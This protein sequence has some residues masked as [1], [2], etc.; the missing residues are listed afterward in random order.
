L[1]S[2]FKL[3]EESGVRY[4]ATK[5][6]LGYDLTDNA[7]V[8]YNTGII[9][10][11]AEFVKANS[12]YL[13]STTNVGA[14]A[15]G[16]PYSFNFWVKLTAEVTSGADFG[17]MGHTPGGTSGNRGWSGVYYSYNSGT[18]RLGFTRYDPTNND[19]NIYHNITLGTDDWHMITL[20]YNSSQLE[21]FVNGS[22]V[23]TVTATSSGG[24]ASSYENPT[25]S[26]GKAN[27]Y[28]NAIIDEAGVWNR[29]LSDAEITE[30]YNSG[31][32]LAYNPQPTIADS[33]T[34]EDGDYGT[35]AFD[36]TIDEI[37]K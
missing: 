3:D 20:T 12:E 29:Q 28:C 9:G 36:L 19:F 1:G 24:T 15:W 11:G 18:I 30:L 35:G 4:D 25:F 27:N 2:Y 7:T 31:D 5:N 17:F 34:Y 6:A 14:T 22:S 23:G 8:L 33:I 26:L 10:N 13:S 32:G 37:L 21:A 16:S